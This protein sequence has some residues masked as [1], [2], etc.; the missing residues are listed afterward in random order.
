MPQP[1]L[2][3]EKI[4]DFLR[5]EETN[6]AEAAK[7]GEA[8]LPI[9]NSIVLGSDEML[10]SKATYMA[11][12]INSTH[13]GEVIANAARH[14]SPIVRVAAAHASEDIAPAAAE[15]VMDIL[16]DDSDIGVTKFA[17]RTVKAKN[18]GGRFSKQIKAMSSGHADEAI[19]TM[20]KGM[21]K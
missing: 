13:K 17:L 8:A 19:K 15:K 1:T 4:I 2:L 18:L 3:A 11:A 9:L 16:M 21:A 6:Y 12:Q 7:L 10:A 14:Q 5:Q 20:A